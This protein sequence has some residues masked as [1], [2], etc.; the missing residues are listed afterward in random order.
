M[1]SAAVTAGAGGD[2]HR[3]PEVPGSVGHIGRPAGPG[4]PLLPAPASIQ[5]G[6]GRGGGERAP[7]L[8]RPAAITRLPGLSL[9]QLLQQTLEET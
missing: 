5:E 8:P 3:R 4:P 1:A 6:L 7:L 2:D 9:L